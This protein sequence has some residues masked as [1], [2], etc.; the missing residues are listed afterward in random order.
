MFNQRMHNIYAIF[1]KIL[2][3]CK[4]NAGN[5]TKELRYIKQ[6]GVVPKFSDLEVM[7]LSLTVEILSIDSENNL[8]S[9]WI[10]YKLFLYYVE[11]GSSP[12]S[13]CDV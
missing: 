13:Y 4:Q 8:F 10:E 1:G 12:P 2:E 5:L 3:I 9:R 11:D 6:G 7:D